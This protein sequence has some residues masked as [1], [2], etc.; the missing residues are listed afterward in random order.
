MVSSSPGEYQ[1]K[2]GLHETQ[3]QRRS[4]VSHVLVWDSSAYVE[5]EAKTKIIRQEGADHNRLV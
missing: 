4:R 5:G 3:A 1:I 2:G